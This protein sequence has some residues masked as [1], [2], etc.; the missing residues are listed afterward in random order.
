MSLENYLFLNIGIAALTAIMWII[1]SVYFQ[2]CL[3]V[4]EKK[5]H[6]NLGLGGMMLLSFRNADF[7]HYFDNIVAFAIFTLAVPNVQVTVFA[8]ILGMLMPQLWRYYKHEAAVTNV[9]KARPKTWLGWLLPSLYDH[10]YMPRF[11]A[12]VGISGGVSAVHGVATVASSINIWQ[13][14]LAGVLGYLVMLFL[15]SFALYSDIK[16]YLYPKTNTDHK[17]HL[18]GLAIG[19]AIGLV[20]Y[21]S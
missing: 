4:H 13:A 15:T 2:V 18:I 6:V 17:A 20:Y 8:W 14:E 1:E 19:H 21:F 12:S 9:A 11:I 16:G 7:G 10:W 3:K 5:G